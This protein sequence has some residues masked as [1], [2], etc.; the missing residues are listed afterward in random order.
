MTSDDTD[1]SL[2]YS[3]QQPSKMMVT[4]TTTDN[5]APVAVIQ[6]DAIET[7]EN[8]NILEPLPKIIS[9]TFSKR[10]KK[11]KLGMI[12]KQGENGEIF[13]SELKEIG[14]LRESPVSIGNQLLLINRVPCTNMDKDTAVDLLRNA[15]GRVT[16]V[17]HN[18]DGMDGCV[19][20]MVEKPSDEE[21]VGL[22][23][24][25]VGY[26]SLI[27][28]GVDA[29]GP[30]VDSLMAVHDTVLAIN[31]TRCGGTMS[32]EDAEDTMRKSLRFVTIQAQKHF[33]GDL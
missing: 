11:T 17:F 8:I 23:F 25:N 29:G 33:R 13:V 1:I 3:D 2:A 15:M 5:A 18:P 10:A 32:P 30:Y 6:P 27:I 22:I 12:L 19:V 9:V 7:N 20:S 28:S 4:R 21:K 26:K 14:M 31:E 24:K 16:V